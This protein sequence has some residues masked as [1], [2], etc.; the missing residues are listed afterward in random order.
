MTK[1][2]SPTSCALR[3]HISVSH[4]SFVLSDS[5]RLEYNQLAMM[6]I[7]AISEMTGLSARQVY[8]RLDALSVLFD[9]HLMTGQRG[10]K[11]LDDY[12]FTLFRR[13]LEVEKQGI[14]RQAAITLIS[15]ELEMTDRK[16]DNPIRNDGEAVGI[17]VEELRERIKEQAASIE[18]L[19]SENG[20]LR[21]KVDQ[22]LPLALPRPRRVWFSWLRRR[23]G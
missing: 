15:E 19:E 7:K 14:S 13:L 22:L 17:L 16:R 3:G 1:P 12:A 21:E 18:R 4:L 11:V 2:D 20:F 6:D 9:G 23:G 5:L 10:K 8:D